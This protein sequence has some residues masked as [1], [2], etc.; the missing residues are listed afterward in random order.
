MKDF[1]SDIILV[2]EM[3]GKS[4]FYGGNVPKKMP[5]LNQNFP[6]AFNNGTLF[7]CCTD[8]VI[9]LITADEKSEVYKNAIVSSMILHI[10][11]I[12]T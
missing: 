11:T 9:E 7:G 6:R 5:F 4:H 8:E 12:L 3:F 2:N 1:S 10:S